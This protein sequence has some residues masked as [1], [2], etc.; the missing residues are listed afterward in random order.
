[1][2]VIRRGGPN[3]LGMRQVN[4]PGPGDGEVLVEIKAAGVAFGDLLLREGL[5]RTKLPVTRATTPPAQSSP[6][7]PTPHR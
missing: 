1:M 6:P 4:L 5:P 7:V 3:V 2:Q